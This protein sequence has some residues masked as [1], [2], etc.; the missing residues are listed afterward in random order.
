[1]KHYLDVDNTINLFCL[2]YIYLPRINAALTIFTEEWNNHGLRTEYNFT[3]KQLFYGGVIEYG[4]HGT[5]AEN[6]VN[7]GELAEYGVDWDGPI[8]EREEE[9]EDGYDDEQ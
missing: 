7:T 8:A 9:E 3:P 1:M 4:I 2:H 6:N 5:S